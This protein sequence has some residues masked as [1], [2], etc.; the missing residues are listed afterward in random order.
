MRILVLIKRFPTLSETFILNQITDLLD[1]G[2]EV[3]IL[4]LLRPDSSLVHNDFKKYKLSEKTHY[5]PKISS[6]SLARLLSYFKLAITNFWFSKFLLGQIA[7]QV[8]NRTKLKINLRYAYLIKWLYERDAF[9]VMH[10]HFGNQ[11]VVIADIKALGYLPKTKLVVSFHGNDLKPL[12]VDLN[13]RKY[14]RLFSL[15]DAVTVNT[16]YMLDIL[17]RTTQRRNGVYILPE[18]LKV[19]SF[20]RVIRQQSAA[21][22]VLFV[23]RLVPFKAP[24][25]AVE[26]VRT[27]VSRGVT[28]IVLTFIGDGPLM[29]K[30]RALVHACKLE[31]NIILLGSQ[32]QERIIDEMNNSDVFLLPGIT[33]KD[34]GRAEAQGLVVQEA[35]AMELPVV[36]SDAGGMKYGLLEGKT[37]FIARE[38]DVEKFVEYLL[39]LRNNESLRNDMG[40]M[41]R[42]FVKDNFDS[43]IVGDQLMEIYR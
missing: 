17:A 30:V 14:Q 19:N 33:E 12:E 7:K 24:D 35:Q 5:L 21:F 8:T 11:G 28:D 32:N 27:I 10:A 13:T 15:C 25:L 23:G 29:E 1:R 41:G 16:Q 42:N 43:K 37:G 2:H 22:K 31:D 4:S 36:V 9:D 20:K 26:I 3:Q 34:S 39:L 38:G 18:A 6:N 40:K